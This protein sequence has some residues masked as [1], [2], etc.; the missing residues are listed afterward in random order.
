MLQAPDPSHRRLRGQVLRLVMG[1]SRK[2]SVSPYLL[3]MRL[4][5]D[6]VCG[7]VEW[8]LVEVDRRFLRADQSLLRHVDEVYLFLSLS[9]A[10]TRDV[11]FCVH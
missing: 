2:R 10:E 9:A 7:L 11:A 4:R 1:R 6:L 5:R 8:V 3:R